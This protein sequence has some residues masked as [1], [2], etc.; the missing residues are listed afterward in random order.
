M[1]T[2]YLRIEAIRTRIEDSF[3]F[4]VLSDGSAAIPSLGRHRVD[5]TIGPTF[6]HVVHVEI[7]IGLLHFFA[8]QARKHGIVVLGRVQLF[9]L[10]LYKMQ[11]S[12]KYKKK[13]VGT[14]KHP[15]FL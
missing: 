6:K 13:M 10:K 1:V 8:S 9:S 12:N 7:I 3:S 15:P 5:I 11:I 14:I 4:F 2:V